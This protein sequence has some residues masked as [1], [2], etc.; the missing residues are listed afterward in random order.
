MEM[1]G[2]E[3]ISTL[4]KRFAIPATIS[5]LVSAMYNIVD[6]IF[7]GQGVGYLGNAAT[8]VAFPL[9][10]VCLAVS[11]LLGIGCASNL[12]IEMGKGNRDKIKTLVGT[13]F[14]SLILCGI[15]LTVVVQIFMDPLLTAFGATE[16]IFEYA[17]CYVRI[18][19]LSMTFLLI[20]TAGNSIIRADGSATYSMAAMLSGAILNIILDPIFIFGFQ[21]GMAGAAWATFISQV[22]SGGMMLL[23]LPKFKSAKLKWRDFIPVARVIPWIARLGVSSLTFQLS[24]L[25]VQLTTNNLLKSYGADSIY[26]SDIPIAVAGIVL[27]INAIYISFLLGITQG[28]QPILGFNYGAKKYERVRET[29]KYVI[30]LCSIVS[31]IAFIGFEVFPGQ[32]MLLFGTGNELYTE[33]AAKYLRIFL[34]CVFLNGS[35]VATTLFFPAIGKAGKGALLSLSRQVIF[36]LPLLV[37]MA[38]ITGVDGIMYAGPIADLLAWILTMFFAIK[39]FKSMPKS[40]KQEDL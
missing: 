37:L 11:L 23:Y 17:D 35:Q 28:A 36:L 12:N 34:F 19:S 22:V 16:Q 21:W 15:I 30:V 32:I 6:Q 8:N 14:G 33:Y 3:K 24:S 29:Y 20:S 7:I 2:Q 18:T 39:E 13:T 27:K 40:T 10:T 4:L 25:A 26:G 9:T 31:I 38:A 1:L 5:Y